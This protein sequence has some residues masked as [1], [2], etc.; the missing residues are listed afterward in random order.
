MT[1]GRAHIARG[2]FERSIRALDRAVELNPNFAFA[3]IFLGVARH[4]FGEAE[5]ALRHAESAVRLCPSDAWGGRAYLIK[6]STLRTLNRI[7][8][9]IEAGKIACDLAP[10]LSVAHAYL[11]AAFGLANRIEEGRAAWRKALEL[12]PE[13]TPRGLIERRGAV[14]PDVRNPLEG[15]WRSLGIEL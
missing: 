8:E 6:S 2:N 7:D 14:N 3:Y 11:A 13:M 10:G 4:L 12:E 5:V 9:S 1:L 15:G